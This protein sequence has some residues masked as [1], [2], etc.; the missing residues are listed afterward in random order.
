MNQGV[1][2][3]VGLHAY[4]HLKPLFPSDVESV[5]K[6]ENCDTE[7][8]RQ[9]IEQLDA[10]LFVRPE[11]KNLY[12]KRKKAQFR[13]IISDWIGKPLSEMQKLQVVI[14]NLP[15]L[16]IAKPTKKAVISSPDSEDILG[17]ASLFAI[18]AR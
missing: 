14:P 12:E 6:P 1:L 2:L 5:L 16:R 7:K 9:A 4:F 10:L 13:K 3:N 17:T 15:P 8:H 18:N 11:G